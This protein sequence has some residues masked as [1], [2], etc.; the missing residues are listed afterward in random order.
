[1]P[2]STEK[3]AG[4]LTHS[5]LAKLCASVLGSFWACNVAADDVRAVP[6]RR[7]KSV[8]FRLLSSPGKVSRGRSEQPRDDEASR[9]PRTNR[10]VAAGR[11]FV[12]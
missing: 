4:K 12:E 5:K 11:A 3:C 10:G 7:Y 6:R 9:R 2:S 1:M 8:T